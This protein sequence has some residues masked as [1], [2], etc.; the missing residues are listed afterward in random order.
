[1]Q[2]LWLCCCCCYWR[3]GRQ[4]LFY[5]QLPPACVCICD[6]LGSQAISSSSLC[7]YMRPLGQS[8]KLC[9]SINKDPL[10]YLEP[11]RQRGKESMTRDISNC[12][13]KPH[14]SDPCTG[15]LIGRAK[16]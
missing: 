4:Q 2:P 5:S 7:V 15:I 14:N 3:C 8:T 16:R 11:Q 12:D 6:C 10:G 13:S 9:E 1:M